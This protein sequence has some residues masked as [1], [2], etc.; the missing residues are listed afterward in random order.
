MQIRTFTCGNTNKEMVT[1]QIGFAALL[2]SK[3]SI[4][5]LVDNATTQD[6]EFKCYS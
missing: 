4:E 3:K 6:L 5:D 1:N 2:Q